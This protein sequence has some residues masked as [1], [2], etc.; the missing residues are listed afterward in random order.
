MTSKRTKITIALLM[1]AAIILVAILHIFLVNAAEASKPHDKGR[2]PLGKT[3]IK[4]FVYPDG[5][6]IGECLE[7]EIWNDELLAQGHTD[8]EGK[9]VFAGL[10]DGTYTI[11]YSWQG[12]E[13]QEELPRIDCSKIVWEFTN[14]VPYWS[15]TKWFYYDT[16]PPTPISD[17]TVTLNGFEGITD[18]SGKVVFDG[19]KAGSYTLAWLWCSEQKTEEVEI[20]FQTPTPVELTNNLEPKSG[21][22]ILHLLEERG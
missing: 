20:G 4:Y 6:P 7:V 5:T 16:V 1:I 2:P 8:A 10:A 13:H 11:V 22:G 12:I 17:L 19:L 3:I 15:L 14:E 18:E 21:G 9:V